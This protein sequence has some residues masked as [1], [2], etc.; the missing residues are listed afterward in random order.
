ML[1][2]HISPNIIGCNFRKQTKQY[3]ITKTRKARIGIKHMIWCIHFCVRGVH[4]VW[5]PPGIAYAM[6]TRIEPGLNLFACQMD[7]LLFL[8]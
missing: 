1:V 6:I 8:L 4:I 7:C 2:T 3:D 5:E